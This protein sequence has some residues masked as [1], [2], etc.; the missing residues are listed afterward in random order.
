[1]SGSKIKVTDSE[2][3]NLVTI[4]SIYLTKRET[5]KVGVNEFEGP[6]SLITGEES[7]LTIRAR[8]GKSLILY[9]PNADAILS[10]IKNSEHTP[11]HVRIQLLGQLAQDSA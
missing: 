7:V 5:R 3:L 8:D 10:K 2:F 9:G 4:S 6:V 11:E 1:M